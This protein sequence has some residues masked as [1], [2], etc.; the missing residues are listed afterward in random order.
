MMS[1]FTTLSRHL[2]TPR[3]KRSLGTRAT[4][5]RPRARLFVEPLEDR[6]VPTTI[7]VTNASL[8]E[9][10]SPSAFITAGSGG[11]SSPLGITVGP[12][13][14]VYVAGNGGA[15]LRYNGTTGAFINTFVSQGSGGLSFGIDAGL[16]FGPDG[17][18]YVTSEGT[19]QILE[20]NGSTGAFVEAF[21]SAGSGGLSDP[22]GV[23]FGSDGNLYVTSSKTNSIMRYQG[24]LASSPGAALPAAGQ[25]GATFVAPSS[26][27]LV[28]PN[29]LLFGPD[30]NLY[31]DGGQTAGILRYN[32]TTGAF[33]NTFAGGGAGGELAYGR[34]IAFDQDGNLYVGDESNAVHRYNSQGTS[35]GDLLV[36]SVNPS[37]SKPIGMTFDAQ[38]ELLITDQD[39]NSVVRY[40]NGVDVTLSAAS[41]TPVSVNFATADGSA[42]AGTNYYA[43]SGTVTFNPG[44][45]SQMILVA[46]QE[47]PQA[48][49]NVSFS[50][51]LSNPTGGA[52]IANGT[53]AVNITVDDTTRQFAIANTAAIEADATAHYRG[54]FVQ[55]VPDSGFTYLTFGPDGNLYTNT[56]PGAGYDAITE[57]N[58]TTGALI[59]LFVPPVNG[60]LG[61]LDGLAF[62]DGYLYVGSNINPEVLQY[63][64]TT[65]AF[66]SVFVSGVSGPNNL[67]FGPDASGDANADLYVSSSSGVSRYNGTTGAYLGTYITNGSG[68]LSNAGAMT[69]DP[70]QTYLYV[71]SST[72]QVLK[73]NAETGAYVGVAASAGV[74]DPVDV[75]FGPNDGLLYVLSAGNNRIL[76]YT[77]TGTYVDDYVTAGSGGMI[78]PVQMAFGPNGDLYVSAAGGGLLGHPADGQIFDFGTESEAVFT[79]TNTTPST[80]PLPVNYATGSSADTAVAGTNY[81][82]TSGTLTFAPGW[83][84]AAIDVPILDSSS[85]TTPLTFTL[86]LSNPEGATLSQ[87]EGTGTIAPSDQAAKFYVVN[88]ATSSIGGTNTAFK[89][90][91]SGTEQAPFNLSLNDLTPMGV[92]ANAAGTMEWVVDANKNVYVYSP[93]GTLLGSWSAGGLSS[94]AQLTGITTNGTDIWLVDSS[95][96]KVYK[97]TGAAS[98]L[99]GS[100]NAASSFSLSVHGHSGNGNPQDIVTDG[101]SFWVVDGTAHMVFKYTLAGSLLGSWTID[102]ANTHPTGITINP[103]N[104]SDIWIVD[105]G[106][107]K[108]Y[109]YI[110]AASRTSGSQNAGAMFALASGNSNPQ[111]IADPPPQS[112]I[113]QTPMATSQRVPAEGRTFDFEARLIGY[114]LPSP[115]MLEVRGATGLAMVSESPDRPDTA[116]WPALA[117]ARAEKTFE[118]NSGFSTY[119]PEKSSGHATRAE[120]LDP[121]IVAQIFADVV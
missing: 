7:S 85:Q 117:F 87:S 105:N 23:A 98:R 61:L 60:Q 25:S 107:D 64:A 121:V 88:D 2:F 81:T 62:N 5:K 32:G 96:Y 97:Y 86:N 4:H 26:G 83:T 92:A 102:P 101:T 89:Y 14:N 11:L 66:V 47:D 72:N 18:L 12:D 45:T 80:L 68:G 67:A 106:T 103:N 120:A 22:R 119:Q 28:R 38:G 118:K 37:L 79:V 40:A 52:T 43:L 39:Y 74:S 63:N 6:A 93:S 95:A 94:S 114:A 41:S 73:Y 84:T 50:V 49:G 78:D 109:Q 99:S 116:K 30:G 44:Q 36:N 104:V 115:M 29:S 42:L 34:G 59:G 17:N 19:N 48:T 112:M 113:P 53:A 20:Y 46:T 24:P 75:K 16:A 3:R 27:G 65:G 71:T 100:Q 90:Q 55:G 56:G 110:G 21:V 57:Y 33:L 69:F 54:A 1:P 51:Q 82:A 77:A 111:G 13:G 91:S 9:I 70:S 58:G 35:L 8:N 10:G 15:V 108:V 76:R 31:V